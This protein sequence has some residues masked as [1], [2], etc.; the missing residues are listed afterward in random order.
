MTTA[1]ARARH[2]LAE[3]LPRP[4]REKLRAALAGR[5]DAREWEAY[6]SRPTLPP[7]HVV[8]VRAVQ[9]A[10]RRHGIGVLVETGTFEGEMVRKCLGAFRVIH[11]IELS[12]R[13]AH[14]A[15]ERFAGVAHVHVHEGDSA[16]RL[17]EVIAS[18]REPAV[19]WLDGH[20]SGGETARGAAD[21]PLAAELEAIARHPVRGHVV[22]VDDARHLGQGDYPS[23][24]E[25]TRMLQAI[26]PDA[27]IS[28]ADDMLRME[29][30]RRNPV[31]VPATRTP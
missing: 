25:V 24:E 7:P 22:L 2:W 18:L 17:P 15:R 5:R 29:P 8:K 27:S 4:L 23:L 16:V 19:F 31:P 10:A 20:F 28:V 9:D 21:T 6:Q 3:R 1:T 13:Y 14:E 26:D 11:T 30:A 12:P